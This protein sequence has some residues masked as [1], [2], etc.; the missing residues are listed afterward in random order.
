M[1]AI[2]GGLSK[3]NWSNVA[4]AVPPKT[5]CSTAEE[6]DAGEVVVGEHQ[7]LV[8]GPAGCH[9][10][11]DEF[12]LGR[13]VQPVDEC[14]VAIAAVEAVGAAAALN[15]VVSGVGLDEV[16]DLAFRPC[17]VQGHGS[18][19]SMRMLVLNSGPSW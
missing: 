12:A 17:V 6:L 11:R 16:G 1:M 10:L 19:V 4:V 15:R 7:N 2:G 14:V 5:N 13:L 9:R 3:V 8:G 18:L